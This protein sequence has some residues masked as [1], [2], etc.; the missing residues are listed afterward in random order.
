MLFSSPPLPLQGVQTAPPTLRSATLP[1]RWEPVP[2]GPEG[3][4]P[5]GIRGLIRSPEGKN[6]KDKKQLFLSGPSP[7]R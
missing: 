5:Y 7:A 4:S 3:V 2:T 6:P 1:D